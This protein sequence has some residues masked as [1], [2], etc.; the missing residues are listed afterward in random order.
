APSRAGV[1][2]WAKHPHAPAQPVALILPC[3]QHVGVEGWRFEAAALFPA[4]SLR[5][6]RG[7]THA[8]SPRP[9]VSPRYAP[10]WPPAGALRRTRATARSAAAG[11]K[12]ASAPTWRPARSTVQAPA[13]G[14]APARP[15]SWCRERAGG[16]LN[17]RC[18]SRGLA[19]QGSMAP[20]RFAGLA[21]GFPSRGGLTPKPRAARPSPPRRTPDAGRTA[22]PSRA[23]GPPAVDR[24]LGATW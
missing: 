1:G 23:A 18:R 19:H 17:P 9:L 24:G 6:A 20:V 21:A 3:P 7:G 15:K 12:S 14:P 4:S 16:D 11:A 22:A 8:A 2:G 13:L 5:C 10:C